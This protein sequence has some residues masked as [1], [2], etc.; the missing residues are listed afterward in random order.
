MTQIECMDSSRKHVRPK[1]CYVMDNSHLNYTANPVM[2]PFEAFFMSCICTLSFCLGEFSILASPSSPTWATSALTTWTSYCKWQ[3]LHNL[4]NRHTDQY[5]GGVIPRNITLLQTNLAVIK[6]VISFPCALHT[7]ED[8]WLRDLWRD[9]LGFLNIW[10]VTKKNERALTGKKEIARSGKHVVS[11][12]SNAA[13]NKT[14]LRYKSYCTLLT[15]LL[16]PLSV[17]M[18]GCNLCCLDSITIGHSENNCAST[19]SWQLLI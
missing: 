11:N 10:V 13:A 6:A 1:V 3:K 15:Q 8:G 12:L 2:T 19:S 14:L 4:E 5:L 16:H 7:R 18:Q 17:C 9:I